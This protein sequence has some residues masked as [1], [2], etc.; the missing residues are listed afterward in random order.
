M[1]AQSVCVQD[2]QAV[3][4]LEEQTRVAGDRHGICYSAIDVAAAAAMDRPYRATCDVQW[5]V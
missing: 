2:C 5:L 3:F 1:R 4:L